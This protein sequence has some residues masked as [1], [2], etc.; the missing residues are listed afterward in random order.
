M[1]ACVLGA[2]A[3]LSSCNRGPSLE[4]LSQQKLQELAE[5]SSVEY[6]VSKVIKATDD[7]YAG[8]LGT[9]Q[10]LYTC[11]A[12]LKAGLDMSE[13]SESDVSINSKAKTISISLPQPKL[14]VLNIKPEDI[15][16]V[17]ENSTGL[18]G[19][20]SSEE[21]TRLQAQGEQDIRDNAADLGILEDAKKFA[22]EYFTTFLKQ[23]GFETIN[24]QFK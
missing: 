16:L 23:A 24:I 17:Y 9:K 22:E 15:K 14:L 10:I 5:I 18:R 3:I 8:I 20:F 6:T 2:G 11:K 12:T 4:N 13:F 1:C 21:H 19:G 7:N